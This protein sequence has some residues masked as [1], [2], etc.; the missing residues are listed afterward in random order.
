MSDKPINHELGEKVSFRAPEYLAE[1]V[2]TF[3]EDYN[4]RIRGLDVPESQAELH[5]I[6]SESE[7]FRRLLDVG[8]GAWETDG[9]PYGYTFTIEMLHEDDFE[10]DGLI[11]PECGEG[12]ETAF[13]A[14]ADFA[15]DDEGVTLNQLGCTQCGE[16]FPPSQAATSTLVSFQ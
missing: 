12:D 2:K 14:T 11:C 3:R 9:L 8:L 5:T 10:P 7:A 16:R 15:G 1:R 13:R 4:E 6:D